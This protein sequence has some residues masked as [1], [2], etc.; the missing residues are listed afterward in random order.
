MFFGWV[1]KSY[2]QGANELVGVVGSL[3][4][5]NNEA[6]S[7][8]LTRAR[9]SEFN[10]NQGLNVLSSW[11]TEIGVGGFRDIGGI[12][13]SVFL[14]LAGALKINLPPK[15]MVSETEIQ[16]VL[17]SFSA[18]MKNAE[19]GGMRPV[20]IIGSL[21]A[22]SI[23][24]KPTNNGSS[25]LR[26]ELVRVLGS[27]Q[28]LSWLRDALGV[29]DKVEP[30]AAKV[31]NKPNARINWGEK[32][33]TQIKPI[34][35]KE[36]IDALW[37]VTVGEIKR[38]MIPTIVEGQVLE[39]IHNHLVTDLTRE[40]GGFVI[41]R[42]SNDPK[43]GDLAHV[44]HFIPATKGN[45]TGITFNWEAE[46]AIEAFDYVES[47]Y[48]GYGIGFVHSHPKMSVGPTGEP[49]DA[50]IIKQHANSPE[51][52]F[53][54]YDPATK[55]MNDLRWDSA[56]QMPIS[57]GGILVGQVGLSSNFQLRFESTDKHGERGQFS[58]AKLSPIAQ[59][60]EREEGAARAEKL[61]A[62]KREEVKR[63][64]AEKEHGG[65][66]QLSTISE[67][68]A[69]LNSA[70]NMPESR[71]KTEIIVNAQHDILVALAGADVPTLHGLVMAARPEQSNRPVSG[72]EV[73]QFYA[74]LINTFL[75]FETIPETDNRDGGIF[76]KAVTQLGKIRGGE[77]KFRAGAVL[78]FLVHVGN[79]SLGDRR[80]LA[81]I[82]L[83]KEDP[84]DS[85]V[86]QMYAD[87][88]YTMINSSDLIA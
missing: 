21:L 7:E 12:K 20:Q 74:D 19:A 49:Y 36:S 50:A 81:G 68:F 61:A 15:E 77:I 35:T 23:M 11:L 31:S 27:E 29:K 78:R 79:M 39:G 9:L 82:V 65:K 80:R 52:P 1:E 10:L 40:R 5:S 37:P 57:V 42:I 34:E 55:T 84:A 71:D 22:E 24:S 18:T 56:N 30:P 69:I 73:S 85:D 60:M 45:T 6:I 17:K 28:N 62:G 46:E 59:R 25:V 41:Y 70:R 76:E 53:L 38:G 47:H 48:S 66:N 14:K 64:V 4:P 26:A 88:V 44:V 33:T 3:M 58:S 54:I 13:R 8:E 86:S 67:C 16:A 75:S 43:R 2:P 63:R 51:K 87:V 32:E 83:G 72:L